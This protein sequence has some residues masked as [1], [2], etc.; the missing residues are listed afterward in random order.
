MEIGYSHTDSKRL[1]VVIDLKWKRKMQACV[2]IH[3]M[4]EI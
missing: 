4:E 3:I 1:Y 2:F